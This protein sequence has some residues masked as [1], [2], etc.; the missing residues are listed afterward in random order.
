MLVNPNKHKGFAYTFDNIIQSVITKHARELLEATEAQEIVTYANTV[1][2][3][4]INL[5]V[6]SKRSGKVRINVFSLQF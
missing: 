1:A 6:S 4:R 5:L 3:R 2:V